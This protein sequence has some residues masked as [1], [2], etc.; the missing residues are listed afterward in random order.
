MMKLSQAAAYFDRTPVLDPDNG[1]VLF[2]GQVDP[3]DDSKR[4]AGAAYRRV[5]SVSPGTAMPAHRCVRVLGRAWVVGTKETDGLEELHRDKYVLQP[6]E[7][8]NVSRL[9]AWLAGTPGPGLWGGVEWVKDT[10]EIDSSSRVSP[11]FNGLFSTSADI[12]VN[13]VVHSTAVAHLVRAVRPLASGVL[14]LT[15]SPLDGFPIPEQAEV[16]N[17]AYNPVAGTYS[18]SSTT[19]LPALLARWQDLFTYTNQLQARFREGDDI[20]VLPSTAAVSTAD[21]VSLRGIVYQVLG[22]QQEAGVKL[23]HVRVS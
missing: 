22:V 16:T 18:T 20:L 21:A 1:N 23:A 5:L 14:G 13:D 2:Y 6:A 4:D 10:K 19:N 15:L 3:Y 9:P 17:R 8:W 11:Q 12:R 7:Q